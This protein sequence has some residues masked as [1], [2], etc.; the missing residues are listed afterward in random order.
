MAL[1]G[2]TVTDDT[3]SPV[4]FLTGDTDNNKKLDISEIWKYSCT[5]ILSTTTTNIAT[6]KAYGDNS[7]H[8]SVTATAMVTVV[9]GTS[10]IAGTTSNYTAL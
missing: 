3:C 7:D 2:V 1:T 10:S 5:T 9:V 4:K 8:K 6:A